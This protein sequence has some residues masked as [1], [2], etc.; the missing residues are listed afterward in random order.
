MD[1]SERAF[2]L[3]ELIRTICGF[4]LTHD[5]KKS[6]ENDLSLELKAEVAVDKDDVELV[7]LLV[8][9]VT[10]EME[11]VELVGEGGEGEI[12][13]E[14]GIGILGAC[15]IT[16]LSWTLLKSSRECFLGLHLL[17]HEPI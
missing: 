1:A 17:M 7:V 8:A 5:H 3:S 2:S 13:L 16:S 14:E 10:E 9:H 6:L 15:E 12:L 4:S 11:Q